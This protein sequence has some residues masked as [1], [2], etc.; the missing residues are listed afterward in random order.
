MSL[1]KSLRVSSSLKADRY[2]HLG[3]LN[4]TS[5]DKLL[6]TTST[7]L[8]SMPLETPLVTP[9]SQAPSAIAL[10]EA[11]RR[12]RDHLLGSL[13][14]VRSAPTPAPLPSCLSALHVEELEYF[15]EDPE[16]P[17][18][19]PSQCW[20]PLRLVKKQQSS[21][22][23]RLP[24]VIL[25]H[26]TGSDKNSQALRQAQYAERG[27]LTAAI[28]T[29][30]HGARVDPNLPYQQAIVQSWLKATATT[31]V[32]ANGGSVGGNGD[33]KKPNKNSIERP[34]LLDV[35]WD[36]QRL[37]DYLASRDDV[38]PQRFGATGESLGGMV[39]WLLAAADDRVAA[40][41][42]MCGVQN[43]RYAVENDCF[44]ARVRSIPHVFT[45]AAKDLRGAEGAGQVDR[46]VVAAVW[47][48]IMP[49]LLSDS[50]ENGYDAPIS[51]GLIA[52]R[53][54]L[55]LTGEIDEKAPLK[56]VEIV[57]EN[58]R[59]AYK[60][61]LMESAGVGSEEETEAR[62]RLFVEAG[63]GHEFTPTMHR[64]VEEFMDKWL[65]LNKE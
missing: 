26:C 2:F 43:F 46:D 10:Q 51:L 37:L 30:Y 9:S 13:P 17:A 5:R 54:C 15:A 12:G 20:V 19:L 56:G 8:R 38:D 52:P 36:L 18:S 55:V 16:N 24:V 59:K 4:Q 42:P 44:H 48:K 64:E 41:A 40:V 31:S 21:L 7:R 22:S 14:P 57:M 34:F 58:A 63:V 61:A 65:L 1:W 50:P 3:D 60:K 62:L 33:N 11:V 47:E 39:T 27:Y 29:R 6:P 28:D 25:I 45:Q 49:S 53:P 23:N 35:V 32:A